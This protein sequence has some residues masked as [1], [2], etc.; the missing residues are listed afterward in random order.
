V[1]VP[2]H[3]TRSDELPKSTTPSLLVDD[4]HAHLPVPVTGL[5]HSDSS[6]HSPREAATIV[7]NE[8]GS[9]KPKLTAR[10]RFQQLVPAGPRGAGVSEVEGIRRMDSLRIRLQEFTEHELA[11]IRASRELMRQAR[12][13]VGWPEY[14]AFLGAIGMYATMKG[15][16][17]ADVALHMT[18]PEVDMFIRSAMGS[19]SHLKGYFDEAI[20]QGC[21]A[22]G[23]LAVVDACDWMLVI[24]IE[25]PELLDTV[26]EHSVHAV[27]IPW[28]RDRPC[29]LRS[30]RGTRST[31][32]HECL[33]RFINLSVEQIWGTSFDEG[34]TE[35]FTRL[36][37]DRDGNPASSN[38]GVSSRTN[39]QKNWEFVR[40]ILP[41]L[42]ADKIAQETVLAEICLRGKTNLLWERFE[43][44][45]EQKNIDTMVAAERWKDFESAVKSGKWTK[46]RAAMP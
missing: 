20:E 1:S 17:G 25:E 16:G 9:A 29:I 14:A 23:Y 12:A 35:Y 13:F 36:L 37:T 21:M 5:A 24:A 46:A 28:H 33:H 26:E 11:E 15:S 7:V 2:L 41:L 27:M 19:M 3:A 22:R 43:A 8:W 38:P 6:V 31:A 40:D 42:G 34:V 4:A 32:I 30:D 18:G 44:A 39:Y 10:Q 45:C